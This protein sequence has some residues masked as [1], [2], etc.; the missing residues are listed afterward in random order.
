MKEHIPKRHLDFENPI[1][2]DK[3]F[4]N[5]KNRIYGEILSAATDPTSKTW[6]TGKNPANDIPRVG[7]KAQLI[8]KEIEAAVL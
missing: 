4:D 7:R 5:T 8:E 3:Q 2:T 6:G 1:V